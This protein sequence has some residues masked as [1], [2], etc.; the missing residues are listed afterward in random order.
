M[1]LVCAGTVGTLLCQAIYYA[2][3]N[4]LFIGASYIK[5]IYTLHWRLYYSSLSLLRQAKYYA[6]SSSSYIGASSSLHCICSAK[7]NIMQYQVVYT[8]APLV[9]F[10][11]S[12]TPSQTLCNIK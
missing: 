1:V 3:S 6:I 7:P 12:A 4:S 9:L 10:V 11:V 8:L 5:V 2:I